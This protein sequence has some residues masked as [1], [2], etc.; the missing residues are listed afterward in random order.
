MFAALLLLLLIA[1]LFGLGFAVK[2][3]LW[4]AVILLALWLVGWLLHPRERR[5][6]YW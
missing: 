1:V 3:L 5:W 2:A 4:V 6:F